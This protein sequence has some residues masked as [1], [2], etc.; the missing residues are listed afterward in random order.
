MRDEIPPRSTRFLFSFI[1]MSPLVSSVNQILSILTIIGQALIASFFISLLIYRK[2]G[3]FAKGII[4]KYGVLFAFVIALMTTFG[5][6]F[7]SE[8]AG[9][10]PC[11]L[12][13]FQRIFMYPQV[14]LFA[15]ALWKKDNAIFQYAV[16]MSFMGLIVAAYHY[17]IQI[18]ATASVICAAGATESCAIRQFMNFG[19]I[20]IPMMSLTAFLLIIFIGMIKRVNDKRASHI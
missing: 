9:F 15:I 18:N 13:W 17:Y 11:K 4:G 3:N 5:S 1:H 20:T 6:L 19:Y 7:F 16:P 10:E 2:G 8:I 12:C 14:I